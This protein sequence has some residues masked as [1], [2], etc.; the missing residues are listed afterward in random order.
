MKNVI[1]KLCTINT[2]IAEGIA[3]FSSDSMIWVMP[4]NI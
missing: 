1:K 2:K 3:D 4:M